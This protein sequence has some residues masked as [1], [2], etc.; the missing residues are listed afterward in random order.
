M[1]IS[2]DNEL[3]LEMGQ[4]DQ[5]GWEPSF[6][7]FGL[8]CGCTSQINKGIGHDGGEISEKVSLVEEDIFLS[9]G[10]RHIVIKYTVMY[11]DIL[12]VSFHHSEGVE[13]KTSAYPKELPLRWKGS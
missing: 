9:K 7:T 4:I 6:H 12:H 10:G 11:V 2:R 8:A 13:L 1:S 3:W 5:M